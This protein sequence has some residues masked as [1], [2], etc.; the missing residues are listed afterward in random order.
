M[1][2]LDYALMNMVLAT[3]LFFNKLVKDEEGAVDVVAIVLLIGVA[4]VLVVL[5][6]D[7]IET[8]LETLLKSIT[9]NAKKAIK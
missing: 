3:R 4:V 8:L 7:S 9:T 2:V 1:E 6:R 5:F